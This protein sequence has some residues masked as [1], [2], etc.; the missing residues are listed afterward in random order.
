LS[1]N[2]NAS[3]AAAARTA[4]TELPRQPRLAPWLTVV[5]LG[6][7]RVDLRATDFVYGLRQSL[8]AETF[9]RIVPLL[10][11]TREVEDIA[12]AGGEGVLPTTVVFLLQA[13]TVH[14]CLQEGSPPAE[15]PG[16]DAARWERQLRLLSR[17]TA[18]PERAQALLAAARV[19]LVGEGEL[20]DAVAGELLACGIGEIGSVRSVAADDGDLREPG[21]TLSIVCCESRGFATFDAVNATFVETGTRW[22]RVA[23]SGPV[24]ELGPTVVPHHSACYACFDLRRRSHEDDLDGFLGYRGT[25][26]R[27][28][29]GAL[30]AHGSALAAQAALEAMRLISGF[31]PPRTVGRCWEMG[32]SSP[33][34]TAHDV[35]KVPRCP[36][37]GPGT[38]ARE[39]WTQALAAA[40]MEP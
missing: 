38:P 7:G 20:A 27:A 31:A 10:D 14:G 4:Q 36:V 1:N 2:A 12:H 24:A 13:L 34:A 6:D 22:L 35:L 19:R 37:C 39:A 3:L 26:Q 15:Q 29:E 11:G 30:A 9:L 25:G 8:L 17:L 28:D 23:L 21:T 5:D 16:V 18:E 32:V 33:V 40:G